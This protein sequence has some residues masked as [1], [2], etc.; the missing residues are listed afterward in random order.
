MTTENIIFI[1]EII[2]ILLLIASAV[3]VAARRLR[4]PYTVGLVIIGLVI[5]LLNQ[6][7]VKFAPQII[8]LLLVP[9]LVFEA[10]F[11][12]L[13]VF[14]ALVAKALPGILAQAVQC[15]AFDTGG[16]FFTACK[17]H[18]PLTG[19]DVFGDIEAKAPEVAER[20]H[21]AAFILRLDRVGT[22]FNNL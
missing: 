3:A 19:N 4:V 12:D 17:N 11:H 6:Q 1:E 18:S 13:V 2:V 20:A 8:M 15:Q 22:V 9:P 16:V 5:T 7:Q 10:A 21:F 14:K